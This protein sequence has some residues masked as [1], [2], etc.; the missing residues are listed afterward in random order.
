MNKQVNDTGSGGPLVYISVY[1][2]LFLRG[3]YNKDKS[4]VTLT[5]K[6]FSE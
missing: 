5:F 3:N 1:L 6:P 2:L 4:K